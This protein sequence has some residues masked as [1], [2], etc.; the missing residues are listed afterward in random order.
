MLVAVMGFAG[1]AAYLTRARRMDRI[2]HEQVYP[3]ISQR[4]AELQVDMPE[5]QKIAAEELASNAALIH[6][7][8]Q[9]DQ[10]R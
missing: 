7:L 4:L 2:F 1:L 10:S 9:N 3:Q 5:F 8:S 6:L